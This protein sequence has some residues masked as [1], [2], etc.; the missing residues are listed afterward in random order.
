MLDS[1]G[2]LV[3]LFGFCLCKDLMWMLLILNTL[4]SVY[5]PGFHQRNVV[6]IATCVCVCGIIASNMLVY[7]LVDMQWLKVS[8]LHVCRFRHVAA[9]NKSQLCLDERL[10]NTILGNGPFVLLEMCHFLCTLS[11]LTS[12]YNTGYLGNYMY[13]LPSPW[14]SEKY[15]FYWLIGNEDWLANNIVGVTLPNWPCINGYVSIH[16]WGIWLKYS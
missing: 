11:L 16:T 15:I 2:N 6:D 4:A 5:I 3:S 10:C 13:V 1:S 12:I 8:T 9:F 14:S 7:T